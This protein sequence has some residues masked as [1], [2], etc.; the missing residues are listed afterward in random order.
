LELG[1]F[2]AD[3]LARILAKNRIDDPRVLLGPR[4]G[5]DAAVLDMGG[6]LLVAK[7]DPIT[8]ATEDIGWYAVQVN[9]NDIA[10]TGAMPMWFLATILVP[11]RFSPEQAEGVFD[12]ILDACNGLG[13]ALVGGHSEVTQGIDRPIVMGSMLGEVDPGRLITT[14]GARE[15][16]S[17]VVTKGIAIEGCAILA[18]ERADLLAEKGVSPATLAAAAGFLANPGISVILD[19]RVAIATAEIHSLH[20]VTE[21]G[22]ATGVREVALASGLGVAVEHGSIPVLPECQ[23]ICQALGLD[24][25]GLLASGAMLITLPAGD[26]PRLVTALEDQGIDGWEIGQMLAQEEGMVIIG[27]DGETPLPEFSRDELARYFSET[28]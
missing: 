19:A 17:V 15:G 6:R 4:V 26:V 2:P 21:G 23:E 9:A 28:G 16:D 3:M 22:L 5:E 10:C 7:S 14:G 13:V 25:L 12:Q 27:R 18:R 8:F 24:P 11:E 20:D 1:K